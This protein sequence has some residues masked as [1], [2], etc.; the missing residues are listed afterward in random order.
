MWSQVVG[1]PAPPLGFAVAGAPFGVSPH[2]AA[3]PK[4]CSGLVVPARLLRADH[5][6][7]GMTPRR[8]SC[9]SSRTAPPPSVPVRS[10]PVAASCDLGRSAPPVPGPVP[11]PWFLTTSTACSLSGL[12]GLLHPASGPG[13]RDLSGVSV[14][15]RSPTRPTL[16]ATHEPYEVC[17]VGSRTASPRPLLPCR[18]PRSDS[19]TNEPSD[20]PKPWTHR[21]ARARRPPHSQRAA[22]H[23]DDRRKVDRMHRARGVPRSRPTD[24][25][26]RYPM[27]NLLPAP[28]RVRAIRS[29]RTGRSTSEPCSADEL[30]HLEF[31]HK[32]NVPSM[33]LFPS[34]AL[35]VPQRRA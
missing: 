2:L 1:L 25:L 5:L 9:G 17:P 29:H 30:R 18:C 22:G 10:T 16:L 13:V 4:S 27:S 34:E 23:A 19:R 3:A 11:S 12:A 14:M 26:A 6:Q 28:G 15:N 7:T 8:L 21:N 24:L 32:M 33:G 35:G 20:T 31:E